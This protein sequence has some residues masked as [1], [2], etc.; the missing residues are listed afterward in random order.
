[1]DRER[2][3]ILREERYARG[4]KLLKTTEVKET[5]RIQNRWVPKKIVFKD[6][7]KS[8]KGTEFLMESIEFNADIPSHIFS[9][10]ALRK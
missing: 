7:L 4:G 5:V 1:V 2:F 6:V 8:G 9:K 3:V 10:A